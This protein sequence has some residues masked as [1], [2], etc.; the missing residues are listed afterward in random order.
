MIVFLYKINIQKKYIMLV[1]TE[2]INEIHI[3]ENEYNESEMELMNICE[4]S[5][6]EYLKRFFS[7]SYILTTKSTDSFIFPML[8]MKKIVFCY[9][10][11]L[12]YLLGTLKDY[13]D[14]ITILKEKNCFVLSYTKD[15]KTESLLY[16]LCKMIVYRDHMHH[17]ISQYT[18]NYFQLINLL[19]S[20]GCDIHYVHHT[21]KMSCLSLLF[22]NIKFYKYPNYEKIVTCLIDETSSV[23][24]EDKITNETY[25]Q[26]PISTLIYKY[27]E[28][29]KISYI[30]I[31]SNRIIFDTLIILLKHHV[32]TFAMEFHYPYFESV[33]YK[34]FIS[35]F[36]DFKKK[37][38]ID[39]K[40]KINLF[41]QN[42]LERMLNI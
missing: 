15:E 7:E 27:F 16:N 8:I 38:R 42:L 31:T 21:D 22:S 9:N 36:I 12:I 41:Y 20:F 25:G 26:Y 24:K 18:E 17:D 1:K 35:F 39:D 10:S 34:N 13:L 2:N 30:T 19:V 4:K 3:E 5:T 23:V 6:L 33:T 29:K 32:P 11:S 14:M 40:K 28:M 37:A